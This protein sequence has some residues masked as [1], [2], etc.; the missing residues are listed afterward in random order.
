MLNNEF[1]QCVN[2]SKFKIFIF[3]LC[4]KLTIICGILAPDRPA[5]TA[6]LPVEIRFARAAAAARLAG[7]FGGILSSNSKSSSDVSKLSPSVLGF[8]AGVLGS[9]KYQQRQNIVK[10]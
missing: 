4:L 3:C 1:V 5:S 9:C 6:H 2:K 10:M 7:R 8:L